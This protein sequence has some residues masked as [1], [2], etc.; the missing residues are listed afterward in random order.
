MRKQE[1]EKEQ[2]ADESA[3]DAPED[4]EAGDEAAASAEERA[5]LRLVR[6]QAALDDDPVYCMQEIFASLL[7]SDK[8]CVDPTKFCQAYKNFDGQ[9][10]DVTEQMD[11][12]E[13]LSF[14]FDKIENTLKPSPWAN[15]VERTFGGAFAQTITCQ[16]CGFVSYRKDPFRVMS[17]EIKGR[18]SLQAALDSFVDAE[19]L[20]GSNA[21]RCGTCD[22][23]VTAVKRTTVEKL[24]NTLIIALKRFEFSVE[25]MAKVKANDSVSFTT[26]LN[27][28]PYTKKHFERTAA[29]SKDDGSAAGAGDGG[30]QQEKTDDTEDADVP[31]NEPI[32]DFYDLVGVV[33]HSGFA[34]MGH[35]YS[36]IREQLPGGALGHV[37]FLR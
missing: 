37:V 17:V 19:V 36:F 24:P 34:E 16:E 22:K 33:V 25:T 10:I 30:D 12:S 6:E 4:G 31:L 8:K 35:Y 23:K 26:T 7:L 11:A 9:P 29:D 3:V 27:M 28:E 1:D 15:A 20:S 21:Y 2:A 14:L 32:N 5:Q 13:F 18:W